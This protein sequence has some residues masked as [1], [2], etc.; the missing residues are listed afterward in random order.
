MLHWNF[1]EPSENA[2]NVHGVCEL[3]Q[4][5]I[6]KLIVRLRPH[7]RK[8]S[9]MYSGA[10]FTVYLEARYIAGYARY[11]AGYIAGYGILGGMV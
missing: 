8:P 1:L 3:R 9:E 11:I 4:Q 7:S 6:H 2:K 5:K 10:Q